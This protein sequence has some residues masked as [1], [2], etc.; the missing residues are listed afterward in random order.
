MQG[1]LLQ[2]RIL[3]AKDSIQSVASLFKQAQD[4]TMGPDEVKDF[5]TEAVQTLS[6]VTDTLVTVA[7]E[8]PST[9]APATSS[10]LGAETPSID[11][12]AKPE[13]TND[14]EEPPVVKTAE[15]DDPEKEEMKNKIA[16]LETTVS[17]MERMEEVKDIATKYASLWPAKL[18][19]GKFAS[20]MK[21]KDSVQILTAR[22]KEAEGMMSHSKVATS[23]QD[24][25]RNT[26][27][28]SKESGSQKSASMN[29]PAKVFINI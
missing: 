15:G 7:E 19:G 20:I 14:T 6:Q 2:S 12:S 3:S 23:T 10:P 18:Q 22:L 24:S 21:S 17:N 27:I 26:G 28:Y 13:G 5:V 16:S 1:K 9:E 29:T 4:G 25:F 8:V 11:P